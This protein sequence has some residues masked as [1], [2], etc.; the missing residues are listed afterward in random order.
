M[1]KLIFIALGAVALAGCSSNKKD[2]VADTDSIV[3]ENV[4]DEA[5]AEMPS[6][7]LN[8]D[9]IGTVYVGM[10]LGEIPQHVDGLYTRRENGASLDA[11]TIEFIQDDH[12]RFVAYDF[13]EGK[14]D[15]INLIGPDVKV[16]TIKGDVGIGDSMATVLDLP[17]VKPEWSGLDGNGMWYWT[18][19]GLWF[20]PAQEN[21]SQ[22]LLQRLYH[23]GQAP[24][25]Q[26]F[27]DE[28]V[29]IGF[30][31]TGLPF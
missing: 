22:G 26:D 29:T 4:A 19:E 11:V 23:S 21:L 5:V 10:P 16:R 8:K 14:I 2:T 28:N 13:G 24:T 17:G 15:V 3:T 27:R 20:A 7:F 18:W 25:I 12:A 30:I 31:G 1:K 9:S 6:V